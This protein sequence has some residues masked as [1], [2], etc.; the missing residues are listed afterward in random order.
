V[1]SEGLEGALQR[2]YDAGVYV[3]QAELRARQPIRRDGLEFRVSE[4]DFDNPLVLAA[5]EAHTSG[6]SGTP[7]RVLLGL[8]LTEYEAVY[9][10]LLL[11]TCDFQD[12]QTALWRPV[13]PD[14]SGLFGILLFSKIGHTPAQWFSQAPLRWDLG[15][16][17][18]TLKTA[19][20]L[21]SGR[22]ASRP[23]PW[24]RFVPRNKAIVVA[25]WLAEQ[26]LRGKP[27]FLDTSSSAAV[28]VCLAARENGLDI[29]GSVFGVSGEPY[30][31]G[32][33]GVLR[34]AGA[35]PL[36]HYNMAQIGKLA[37]PCAN[38]IAL[39][40]LHLVTDKVAVIQR[41]MPVGEDD[42]TV[43]A[44]YYTT[45]LPQCPRL[46]INVEIGDYAR[47]EQRDCGCH[48][49]SLGF[50]THLVGVRGYDKLTSEGVT[51]LGNDLFRLVEEE[52]P[53]RFGGHPTD[54]QLVEQ[55]VNGLT[56]IEVVVSPVVDVVDEQAV[57]EFVLQALPRL[58][59]SGS[60]MVEQWRQADTLRV[61]RREP[62][63]SGGRKILP[64]HFLES[65]QS[66]NEDT[67]SN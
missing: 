10:K 8:E 23:L 36:V 54:Y 67:L 58:A 20:I 61:V 63:A 38:P 13:P 3:T 24:P 42:A 47:L 4:S 19:L 40:D 53:A 29:A 64:L 50:L 12:G 43:G 33:D 25:R 37:L 28:R 31:R 30:T 6:S 49:A 60:A 5:Y 11:A 27:A 1:N 48:L 22:L 39:D 34:M 51:F 66:S 56:R 65:R 18:Q 32:K 59:S 14:A 7:S 15:G 26:K 41:D 52:L 16:L 44:L 45:V 46:M 9:S 21:F 57:L 55:E 17:P 2:L 35:V 62:Y